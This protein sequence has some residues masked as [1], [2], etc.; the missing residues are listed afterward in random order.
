M[1]YDHI[2]VEMPRQKRV[3]KYEKTHSK[4]YVYEIIER[5]SKDCPKDKVACVGVAIDDSTMHP[6]DR[7]Y[8]LHPEMIG[9]DT[10]LKEDRVFDTQIHI[11]ASML[12]RAAA[13]KVGLLQVLQESFP[14]HSELIQTLVEYYILEKESASQLYKYYLYDHYTELNYIPS[15]A[16]L[17]RLFNEY[18]TH[19]RIMTFLN[20]WM[21]KRLQMMGDDATVEIDFDSTNF[22]VNSN[23]IDSAEYGKAKVDEGLPQVN[24]AY[25]LDRKSGLPIYYDVYCGSIIDL[26]HCKTAID[27]VK[28]IKANV[29]TAFVMDRGYFSSGN[30]NYFEENGMDYMCMGRRTQEFDRLVSVYPYFRIGKTENWISG[31]IYGVKEQGIVFQESSKTYYK[32]F[33]YDSSKT[34]LE[35]PE[36][37]HQAEHASKFVIGK[38]DN[39][40][41]IR[42]TYKNLLEMEVD[43]KDVII[44]A[45]L[46]TKRLDEIRDNTGYFWI[47]SNE[48]MTPAEALNAYRHRDLIE[49]TFKGIKTDSDLNK[50]YA[51]TD[52]AFEAKSLMAFITAVLRAEIT[53]RLKPYFIQYYNE[54]SQT[55]LREVDKIKAEEIGNKYCLRQALTSRQK[56]ILAFYDMTS[57][58]VK[59][60]ISSVNETAKFL[61]K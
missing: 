47:V 31:N 36:L 20:S 8:E 2:T 16:T 25:F 26:E 17:S 49:K 37:L 58:E 42:N 61:D 41:F 27:K 5:K 23:F 12:L 19:D 15:D 48:D 60:Y 29:K 22:N 50:L 38:R 11:G 33:F 32:Y 3:T 9:E 13:D 51:S 53:M 7:Y 34:S 43:D 14:G 39:K 21:K 35:M 54:T 6:N 55:A 57:A 4:P 1:F 46:N 52:S 45:K 56:Q 40:G 24:V 18:L 59:E 28:R 10:K 30:L 44:S